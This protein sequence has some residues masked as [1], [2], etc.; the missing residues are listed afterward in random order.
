MMIRD[1]GEK[2]VMW[3]RTR[4]GL[5]SDLNIRPLQIICENPKEVVS[6]ECSSQGDYVG[7]PP[8]PCWNVCLMTA[9]TNRCVYPFHIS[10]TSSKL[11][12]LDKKWGIC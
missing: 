8:L 4:G 11:A 9:T 6:G 12:H 2:G 7:I 1:S 10:L 5:H 3:L